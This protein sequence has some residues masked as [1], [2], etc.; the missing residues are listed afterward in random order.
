MGA[1][2]AAIYIFFVGATGGALAAALLA[3]AAGP[4]T[5]VL[6]LMV[7]SCLVG[8]FL[9]VRSA[10]SI[11]TDLALVVGELEE[12]QAEAR[13]RYRNRGA[14][15]PSDGAG[16]RLESFARRWHGKG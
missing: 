4:R 2:L 14:D 11:K 13:R 6:V 3:D 12:E 5:A 8:G 10:A 7:P 9:V 15:S 16:L 1:A